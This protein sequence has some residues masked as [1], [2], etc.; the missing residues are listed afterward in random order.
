MSSV[1]SLPDEAALAT[2]DISK[3][4]GEVANKAIDAVLQAHFQPVPDE[5]ICEFCALEQ[6]SDEDFLLFEHSLQGSEARIG[7]L[8]SRKGLYSTLNSICYIGTLW[9]DSL[10]EE[11]ESHR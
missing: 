8:S 2:D 4:P 7:T 1:R 11:P 5:L 6:A 9:Y 10:A 3:R